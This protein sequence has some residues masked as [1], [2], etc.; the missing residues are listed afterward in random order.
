MESTLIL[1]PVLAFI[2]TCRLINVFSKTSANWRCTFPPST[3]CL[4]NRHFF[5]GCASTEK[6]DNQAQG[7]QYSRRQLVM[8][9]WTPYFFTLHYQHPSCCLRKVAELQDIIN[10]RKQKLKNTVQTK[11]YCLETSVCKLVSI[12]ISA[13][14]KTE[15]FLT[16]STTN[17]LQLVPTLST[18][19][20]PLSSLSEPCTRCQH[21][22]RQ[23]A[24]LLQCPG[25][26]RSSHFGNLSNLTVL[27]SST[28]QLAAD[29]SWKSLVVRSGDHF[30]RRKS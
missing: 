17:Q 8:K 20:F 25:G 23:I 16:S 13:R 26:P 30:C 22:E 28:I 19:V 21:S 7:F 6:K 10:Q 14:I 29:G 11:G 18:A 9:F 5:P 12:S 1:K 4:R 24:R 2:L 27:F 3:L 15:S